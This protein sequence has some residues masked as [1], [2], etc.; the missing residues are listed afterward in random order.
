M[1]LNDLKQPK[2]TGA[3]DMRLLQPTAII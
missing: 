2:R 3:E 1:T